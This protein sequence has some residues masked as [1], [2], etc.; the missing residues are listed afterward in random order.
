MD[1]HTSIVSGWDLSSSWSNCPSILHS[2]RMLGVSFR[3]EQRFY[4]FFKYNNILISPHPCKLHISKTAS[5]QNDKF[6][7]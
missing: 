3:N 5:E 6:V 7:R 2:N 1:N 4:F